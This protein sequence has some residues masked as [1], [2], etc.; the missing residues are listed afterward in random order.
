[1]VLAFKGV[2]FVPVEDELVVD[3][4]M[5]PDSEIKI[6]MQFAQVVLAPDQ[7]FDGCR[8]TTKRPGASIF[9]IAGYRLICGIRV[10]VAIASMMGRVSSLV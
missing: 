10:I 4:S 5:F 3:S 9:T 7:L 2:S 6:D 8:R 1:M